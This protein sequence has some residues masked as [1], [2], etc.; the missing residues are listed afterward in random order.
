MKDKS[1][2]KKIDKFLDDK[3]K[4]AGIEDKIESTATGWKRVPIKPNYLDKYK[5]MHKEFK[6]ASERT[7]FGD[8]ELK[9]IYVPDDFEIDK[10]YTEEEVQELLQKYS[11]EHSFYQWENN[12]YICKS[13]NI[14][15]W[16]NKNKKSK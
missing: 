8:L 14:N 4:S 5:D 9:T 16:F 6:K 12:Q 11:D 7:V 10:M 13:N 3:A 1:K 15:E 2:K